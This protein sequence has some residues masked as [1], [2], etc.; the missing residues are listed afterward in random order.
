VIQIPLQDYEEQGNYY[1]DNFINRPATNQ[2]GT[3]TC[4]SAC[5]QPACA[6]HLQDF[7]PREKLEMKKIYWVL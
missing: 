3:L 6:G 7:S 1:L 4:L 2:E 5:R